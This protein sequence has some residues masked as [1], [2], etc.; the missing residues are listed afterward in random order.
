MQSTQT[1]F[2]SMK[3]S[4]KVYDDE[5]FQQTWHRTSRKQQRHTTNL[6]LLQTPSQKSSS[7]SSCACL[8]TWV[9][10]LSAQTEIS[11]GSLDHLPSSDVSITLIIIIIILFI[12]FIIITIIINDRKKAIMK[13]NKSVRE[14]LL[15]INW[16]SPRDK[17]LPN[18]L[19][20]D[21]NGVNWQDKAQ[22]NDTSGYVQ[23]MQLRATNN[24]P[25]DTIYWP[26]W[27]QGE[28]RCAQRACWRYDGTLRTNQPIK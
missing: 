24:D 9:T 26:S 6:D 22:K 3:Q 27:V 4:I 14:T 2:E 19:H 17:A 7:K 25:I 28:H 1:I 18:P 12:I 5:Q 16:Y 23:K 15:W 20:V 8:W 10:P 11:A 21:R 13:N